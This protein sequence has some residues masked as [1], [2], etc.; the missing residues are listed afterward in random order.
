MKR[1]LF[2]V[3]SVLLVLALSLGASAQGV[4]TMMGVWGGQ[5]LEAFQEVME[6]FT[7][8]TGITV[9]FEGTVICPPCCRPVLPLAILRCC[10]YSWTWGHERIC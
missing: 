6:A 4:V 10:R 3:F 7:A 2:V 9:Q 8:K 1:S 5:E